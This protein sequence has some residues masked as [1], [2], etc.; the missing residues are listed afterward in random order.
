M[1]KLVLIMAMAALVCWLPGQAL[2]TGIIGTYTSYLTVEVGPTT[3]FPS[4]M[5]TLAPVLVTLNNSTSAT[6]T[7]TPS[8]VNPDLDVNDTA[9]GKEVMLNVNGAFSASASY[10][11][12]TA[13]VHD[14]TGTLITGLG[15]F[16]LEA[17]ANSP[18]AD[19]ESFTF[20]LTA[21]GGNSWAAAADVLVGNASGYDA[22]ASLSYI[23]GSPHPTAVVG[24]I[25]VPAVPVPTTGLLLGSGLLGLVA[26]GWRKRTVLQP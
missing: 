21:T 20:T 9:T 2:A 24:E 7:V 10:D 13:T 14:T 16:N 19:P 12:G 25:D 1:K 26:L 22:A 23:S 4:P 8:A 18:S 11:A 3:G 17:D 5:G 6:V 15:T